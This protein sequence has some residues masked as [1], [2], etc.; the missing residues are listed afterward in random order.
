VRA[1][2]QLELGVVPP[3]QLILDE[4]ALLII[5]SRPEIEQEL[6]FVESRMEDMSEEEDAPDDTEEDE[7]LGLVE[8]P[9]KRRAKI[10]L[11]KRPV[12][13]FVIKSVQPRVISTHQGFLRRVVGIC[14]KHGFRHSV[15]DDR[16]PLPRPQLHLMGGFRGSQERLTTQLLLSPI[17]GCLRAPTRYGKCFGP[18]TMIRTSHG[19]VRAAHIRP[20]DMVVRPDGTLAKVVSTAKGHAPMLRIKPL[21]RP[22]AAWFCTLDHP[23]CIEYHGEKLVMRADKAMEMMDTSSDFRT[24]VRM[25]CAMAGGRALYFTDQEIAHWETFKRIPETSYANLTPESAR[26][27]LLRFRWPKKL[28]NELKRAAQSLL[29]SA[30]Y[31]NVSPTEFVD[32]GLGGPPNGNVP[33]A[34]TIDAAGSGDFFGWQI[35]SED[36]EFLLGDGTIAHN[37]TIIANICRAFPGVPTVIALPGTDLVVQLADDIRAM[38]PERHVVDIS[39]AKSRKIPSPDITV[40]SIDSLHHCDEGET[41]LLLVDE[42]HAAVT[43]PRIELLMKFEKA[44]RYAIGATLGMRF[45]K[46]DP[47]IEGIF[48]PVHASISFTEA[49]K[50]GSICPIEAIM[51]VV[52]IGRDP[53]YRNRNAAYD[54]FFFKSERMAA[55]HKWIINELI[56]KEWQAISFIKHEKQA[57]LLLER[58]GDPNAVIAMAKLM[59][60]K[61]VRLA[62]F[63]RMRKAEI[64]RALASAIYAQGVTF[65][66][67]RVVTNMAGGG[68]YQSSVQKPGRLGQ[69][70]PGKRCGVLFDFLFVPDTSNWENTDPREFFGRASANACLCIDAARRL[71]TYR[72]TGYG[73]NIVKTPA[74][75]RSIF[76]QKCL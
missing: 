50:E 2:Q 44:R 23:L 58:A 75:V 1:H 32:S 71:Q 37:T 45:D 12:D 33:F 41:R 66:D 43:D 5:N 60:Q 49:V 52:P 14:K 20:G 22:D 67:I 70:R 48:G 39:S 25:R 56:P 3:I 31:R 65:P 34:F 62:V 30:G 68:P 64:K 72:D 74:E 4:V 6:K 9:P 61:K 15:H 54:F 24:N 27:I 16:M 13:M 8:P 7:E 10:E 29:W 26:D 59:P 42:P 57:R 17:S 46:R 55:I 11:V 73:I 21:G 51:L 35:D 38:L 47:L 69:I 53:F 28:S 19:L 40:C 36:R 63:E 18:D 76:Q